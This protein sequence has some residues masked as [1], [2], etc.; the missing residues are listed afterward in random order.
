MDVKVTK[1]GSGAS[2]LRRRENKRRKVMRTGKHVIHSVGGSKVSSVGGKT[3]ESLPGGGRGSS[4]A[5]ARSDLSLGERILVEK[6]LGSFSRFRESSFLTDMEPGSYI[7][8]DRELRAPPLKKCEF[9]PLIEKRMKKAIERYKEGGER[10]TMLEFGCADGRTLVDAA[11]W[12]MDVVGVDVNPH[13]TT[14]R[15]GS[16]RGENQE[17]IECMLSPLVH[18]NLTITKGTFDRAQELLWER[19]LD[20]EYDFVISRSAVLHTNM[21]PE[22]LIQALECTK[23]GG[24]FASNFDLSVIMKLERR[25][26]VAKRRP[27]R[28]DYRDLDK[29]GESALFYG[30]RL[31]KPG[32]EV[33]ERTFPVDIP[34]FLKWVGFNV[35]RGWSAFAVL[36]PKSEK[37]KAKLI[38]KL[39]RYLPHEYVGSR[40]EEGWRFPEYVYLKP[41]TWIPEK[42]V[43]V[44]NWGTNWNELEKK[45]LRAID[46][47]ITGYVRDAKRNAKEIKKELEELERYVDDGRNIELNR[48]FLRSVYER[49]T[50]LRVLLNVAEKRKRLPILDVPPEH[51][52]LGVLSAVGDIA[53]IAINRLQNGKNKEAEEWYKEAEELYSSIQGHDLSG[54]AYFERELEDRGKRVVGTLKWFQKEKIKH[55]YGKL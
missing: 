37:K 44:T 20:T 13:G 30:E 35:E 50:E 5:G 7:V 25:Y 3:W 10:P 2:G 17:S 32:F 19:G 16:F 23:P 22:G 52:T 39:R 42:F 45:C 41:K 33:G 29:E 49:Y 9:F 26:L 31:L 21:A 47:V 51:Y 40:M 54:S 12:G 24:I 36:M 38:E 46:Y 53:D 8:A 11:K 18:E 55:R 48:H 1:G 43:K 27:K 14:H 6:R 15:F 28:G 4:P 34:D